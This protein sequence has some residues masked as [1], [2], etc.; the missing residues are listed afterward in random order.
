MIIKARDKY[1]LFPGNKYRKFIFV[2]NLYLSEIKKKA[3]GK[4][5][6]YN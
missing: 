3:D 4:K 2:L 5:I 6:F 1:N